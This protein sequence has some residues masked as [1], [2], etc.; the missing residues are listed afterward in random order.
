MWRPAGVA[1]RVVVTV[2]RSP[3]V[4]RAPPVPRTP[5]A[6]PCG[7][8]RGGTRGRR[9]A[10]ARRGGRARSHASVP[11]RRTEGTRP[12]PARIRA[13]PTTRSRCWRTRCERGEPMP[14][15]MPAT[16]YGPAPPPRK[17]VTSKPSP[18]NGP[19]RRRRAPCSRRGT[20][21]RAGRPAGGSVR[22]GRA[23]SRLP[24]RSA[25]SA[26]RS[27]APT[28]LPARHA[29]EIVSAAAA[30]T[31]APDRPA[32]PQV[33]EVGVP[34]TAVR[35][36][37]GANGGVVHAARGR[38]GVEQRHRQPRAA[39]PDLDAAVDAAASVA[40]VGRGQA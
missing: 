11:R 28:P 17:A 6:A 25:R 31:A 36:E 9:R 3:V 29:S 33:H 15:P 23:S 7:R 24:G 14:A 18:A 5:A 20:T 12:A 1:G 4:R 37:A 27:P 30:L 16:R 35:R 22:G 13:R 34:G 38:P 8:P 26:R 19:R 39:A 32:G 10:R 21:C 40:A 2:G